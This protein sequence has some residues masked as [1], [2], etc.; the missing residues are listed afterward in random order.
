MKYTPLFLAIAVLAGIALIVLLTIELV[1]T[2]DESTQAQ[3]NHH[4]ASHL[5]NV[6][7]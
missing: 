1:Q 2:T 6:S 3:M 7:N 4:K 5:M